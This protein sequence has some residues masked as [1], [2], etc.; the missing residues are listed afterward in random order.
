MDGTFVSV[1]VSVGLDEWEEV[2]TVVG[3][4]VVITTDITILPVAP[5]A[6]S[7]LGRKLSIIKL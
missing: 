1:G 6:L 4:C 3:V 7:N 5:V 2:G